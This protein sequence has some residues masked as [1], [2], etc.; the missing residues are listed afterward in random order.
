MAILNLTGQYGNYYTSSYDSS[1]A[2][3]DSQRKTNATYIY[4]YLTDKG[5]SLNAICGL[6]GNI[7]AESSNN[8][9]RWQSDNVG[10]MSGGYGLVQW[11]PATKYIDWIGVNNHPEY[12]DNNLDR[13]IYELNH[14]LQYIP[15]SAYPLTFHEYT[16]SN[17]TPENL[18]S[19]WLKNYERAGVEVESIRRL[20]ARSWYNYFGGR[21][22]PIHKRNNKFKWVLY[23]RKI[24]ERTQIK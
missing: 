20:N 14:N 22:T 13:I 2:L 21:P 19:V 6:L 10:N 23:S 1:S 9:G 3:N 12:M 24:R 18:A 7:Q 5:W 4:T 15:T 17:D 11:T 16:I 8:P